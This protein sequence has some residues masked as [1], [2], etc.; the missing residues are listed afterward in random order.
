MAFTWGLIVNPNVQGVLSPDGYQS[1]SL[2]AAD[3]SAMRSTAPLLKLVLPRVRPFFGSN[4]EAAALLTYQFLSIA[5]GVLFV[6]VI[7]FFSRRLLS[8]TL[9]RVLFTLSALSGGFALLFFGYVEN[10]A[11][12]IAFTAATFLSG[13]AVLEGRMGRIGLVLPALFMMSVHVFGALA[14][15]AV[16]FAL[17]HSSR[18]HFWAR[19]HRLVAWNT[20][21]AAAAGAGI[22]LFRVAQADP[23]IP[24]AILPVSPT[25]YT[26]EGY[27]LFSGKHLLDLAN[28]LFLLFPGGAICAALAL[29]SHRR[30]SLRTARVTFF[31]L[32]AGALW[33]GVFLLSP[34]LGMPR[35]WDLFA[36]A[37]VP[38]VLFASLE[39]LRLQSKEAR[40]ALAGSIVAG[41]AV[42]GAR[43]A[44]AR[45][46]RVAILQFR[47]DLT[48]DPAKGRN[49][50]FHLI[51]HYRKVG[52]DELA[53]QVIAE[54]EE[55]YPERDIMR[56][57]GELH[58][59]GN[60]AEAIPLC[61]QVLA[62]N[63]VNNE[64][65]MVLG[66]AL[67]MVGDYEQAC[68]ASTRAVALSAD[69][70]TSTYN[71]GVSYA[72]LHQFPEAEKWLR[73]ALELSPNS[74][75]VNL[76]Y[77]VVWRKLGRNDLFEKY[78]A[79]AAKCE[80]AIP[81]V[82]EEATKI[83]AAASDSSRAGA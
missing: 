3:S 41:A 33:A 67:L 46:D 38:L 21:L 34:E 69:R 26:N 50:Y 61:K 48:L 79:R 51:R 58:H 68:L 52:A 16:A 75:R 71:L 76:S 29:F 47:N 40:L 7:V 43:V 37:G 77:A 13:I 23:R 57:A 22:V 24:V 8:T 15:P 72:G 59:A 1:I 2:L 42:L 6:L 83:P 35:D 65:Y 54:W 62:L 36:F 31:V 28:L 73:E 80:G 55:R 19:A 56:R 32:F 39:I 11:P 9:D 25:W 74:F 5:S 30:F 49:G 27:T 66:E 78:L 82:I 53:R 70:L 4:A 18:W 63:P 12:F 14:L 44:E 45:V 17:F 20:L 64:A 10:Y 60:S 81:Q